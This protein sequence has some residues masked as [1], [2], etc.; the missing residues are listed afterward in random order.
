MF[1]YRYTLDNF[2]VEV[3]PVDQKKYIVQLTMFI[4]KS[5]TVFGITFKKTQCN[6]YSFDASGRI[7]CNPYETIKLSSLHSLG[8][9]VDNN[10]VV[11]NRESTSFSEILSSLIS[12]SFKQ[13]TLCSVVNNSLATLYRYKSSGDNVRIAFQMICE[14]PVL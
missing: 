11:C 1:N 6:L 5:C 10:G 2:K 9:M 14:T 8:F 4:T 3:K 12:D 13:D 7:Y